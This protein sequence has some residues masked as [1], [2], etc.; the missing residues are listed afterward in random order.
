MT[1]V[2]L[3]TKITLLKYAQCKM[4]S[5]E[6]NESKHFMPKFFLLDGF[7]DGACKHVLHILTN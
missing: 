4:S 5:F 7:L 1:R 2:E 6:T 3:V